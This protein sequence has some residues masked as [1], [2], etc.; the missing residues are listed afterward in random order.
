[1]EIYNNVSTR[2]ISIF[3]FIDQIWIQWQALLTSNDM[4]GIT[5]SIWESQRCCWRSHSCF[6]YVSLT[7]FL[8]KAARATM[9]QRGE[10]VISTDRRP[11]EM[12]TSQRNCTKRKRM[13]YLDR[14]VKRFMERIVHFP[15]LSLL[16]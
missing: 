16:R 13:E 4:R 5:S 15:Y 1:M 9:V 10:I 7:I 2:M 3:T 11:Q 12:K 6:I 14:I 8:I